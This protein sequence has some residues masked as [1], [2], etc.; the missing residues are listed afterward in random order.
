MPKNNCENRLL[1]LLHSQ[2]WHLDR[3]FAEYSRRFGRIFQ[4]FNGNITQA[5]KKQLEKELQNFHDDLEKTMEDQIKNSFAISDLCADDYAKDY[6][7]GMEV[8]DSE[9]NRVL[10]KNPTAA[11]A[12][13][14]RTSTGLSLSD[15]VWKVTNQ[16]RDSINHVLESGIFNGRPAAD[17]AR[18]IQQYLKEP[19]RRFRR[20]RNAE[21][22]LILSN[23]AKNYHPGQ[24]VYRSSYQN[25]LRVTRNEV[26]IAYRSNDFERRK[27]MP[28]VMGQ[29]IQLSA[30]H[31]QPCICESL[32]GR[33]PADFKFVGWH[34]NCLCFS[35]AILLPREK[36]KDY[37]GG[38][39]I[40]NRHRV[41]K[42]PAHAVNYINSHAK[43]LKGYKSKPFFLTDNFKET[44]DG[45]I[46][47]I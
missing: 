6:L 7:K 13:L 33:Y 37:L 20:I 21:G 2:E 1:S 14:K 5:Q 30:A 34:P 40:D 36:M 11:A 9:M 39:S 46:P 4:N 18:D 27:N 23:P 31:S 8:K 35:T 15:R 47:K 43:T 24:G 45:F 16:T 3:H 29:L 19:N 17:M 28:F 32:T 38:G 41:K 42:V 44:K 12:F 22:K 10:A 26:N 25:A